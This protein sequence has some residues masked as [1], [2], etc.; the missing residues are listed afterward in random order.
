MEDLQ[1]FMDEDTRKEVLNAYVLD[2]DVYELKN[3]I[4]GDQEIIKRSFVQTL[5]D[6][7]FFYF[8]KRRKPDDAF[9][10]ADA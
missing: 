7:Y 5:D 2:G 8:R 10:N 6:V 4:T 3:T 9:Q 1:I